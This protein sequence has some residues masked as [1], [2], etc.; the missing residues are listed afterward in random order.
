MSRISR[1]SLIH[2]IAKVRAMNRRQTEA[3]IQEVSRHQPNIHGCVLIQRCFGVSQDKL[4]FLVHIMLV[5]FQAMK[6][7][8]LDW[9]AISVDEL[10]RHM[11]VY[12]D[13]VRCGAHMETGARDRAMTRYIDAHAERELFAY[14]HEET[15]GWL[16]TTVAEETDRY[17]MIVVATLVS[18][19]AHAPITAMQR[20]T[21][22]IMK[23][24]TRGV[25]ANSLPLGP[26]QPALR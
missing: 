3:L 5:F 22:A 4:N 12:I 1:A 26:T 11:P 16:A 21:A 9:P 6:E 14:V 18:C 17:I 2:A 20:S 7:S 24:P 19:I 25:H 15:A 13:L 10:D 23:S 8:E